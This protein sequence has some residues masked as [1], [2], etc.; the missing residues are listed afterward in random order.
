MNTLN[1]DVVSIFPSIIEDYCNESLLKRAQEEGYLNLRCHDLRNWS[2]NNNHKSVDDTPFGGGAGMVMRPE[3][4][5]SAVD[6]IKSEYWKNDNPEI[7]LLS[8]QG[9]RLNQRI[10][11]NLASTKGFI[12]LCGRYE[13]VDERVRTGLATKEISIGDFVLMGGELAALSLVEST[14]RLQKGL[15]S[16]RSLN[17][18]SF[19]NNLLEYPQYTRPRDFRG[20]KV[21]EVLLSGN[22]QK[23]NLWRE[24]QALSRTK[25]RRP[26][27]IKS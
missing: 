14:A 13:G 26:D 11:E 23:I 6:F 15:I 25:K 20:M 1:V 21:P 18:E 2:L 19:S 9:E 8:P 27:L 5:F 4:F 22:H 12:L 10:S 3:P 16:E 17:E 7:I 24:K